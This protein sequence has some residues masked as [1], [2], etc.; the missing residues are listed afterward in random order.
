MVKDTK[1]EGDGTFR[2]VTFE[3]GTV[4]REQIIDV[5]DATKRLVWSVVGE[6]FEHH[7]ASV[8]VAGDSHRCRVVWA[9]DLLPN[10]LAKTV[11]DIMERGLSLTKQTQEA[12]AKE[13]D[14]SD[15]TRE[16]ESLPHVFC[17]ATAPTLHHVSLFVSDV[18][19]A[20]RFYT[21]GLGL[22]PRKDFRDILGKR[23]S[24]DFHFGVASIF[25]EAGDGRY[26]ELHPITDATMSQPGFPLNHLALAVPDVDVVYARALS[27]GGNAFDIPVPKQQWD[28]TPLDVVMTGKNPEPMRMAFLQGPS[29]ELV[30]LYQAQG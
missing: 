8:A 25:L 9:A 21:K 30:E 6:P 10:E 4:L 26:I 23:M 11:E 3:D 24:G 14:V 19:A 5:D 16:N 17:P 29:G 2:V 27:A 7:N 12:A 20:I 22:L 1:I 18:D 15:A 28:G 13:K